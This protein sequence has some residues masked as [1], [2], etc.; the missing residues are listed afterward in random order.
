MKTIFPSKIMIAVLL[1][2]SCGV[3][4]ADTTIVN[5]IDIGSLTTLSSF[6]NTGENYYRFNLPVSTPVSIFLNGLSAGYQIQL[7][8]A[9]G[10]VLKSS[11]NNG[12]TWT[13]ST[14][15]GTTGGAIVAALNGG[16]YYYVRVSPTT[17][18]GNPLYKS[19]D[20]S[21]TVNMIPDNAPNTV[22]VAAANSVPI[23]T[24]TYTATGINDQNIINQAITT[25]GNAGGGTVLL[26][27]GTYV[28]QNNIMINYDN[29]TLTGA[30]WGTVLKLANNTTLF[31]AGLLRSMF[32]STKDR[33]I[34]P[35]FFNQRFMHLS[36]HGNKGGA[37]SS[38]T[39]YGVY[40][41][42]QNSSF[43]DLR[44][45][46][47]PAYGFDTHENPTTLTPT[48]NISIT[49]SLA[50]HNAKNGMTIDANFNSSFTDNVADSNTG[51]GIM[52][53]TDSSHNT[54]ARN[55]ITNNT[56]HGVAI[57]PG[58]TTTRTPIGNIIQN[59]LIKNN[60]AQ[61]V[62][63]SL[64]NYTQILNNTI[65]DN[66]THAIQLRSSSYSTVDGNN[67]NNNARLGSLKT[68]SGVYL[69]DASGVGEIYST[70]NLIQNNMII[71]YTKNAYKYGVGEI[72]SDDDYNQIIGNTISK[73]YIPIQVKGPHSTAAGNIILP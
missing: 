4:L 52:L 7:L 3:S 41:T 62:Y 10:N 35:R 11:S 36:L 32:I 59:N 39:G 45:H 71:G 30:G 63:V 12:T 57:Q 46:D 24:T 17:L 16:V 22:T 9:N 67:L 51:Y 14:N 37:T 25:M 58:S 29:I 56:K 34:K 42:Y 48:D 50:D 64:S 6:K 38:S 1:T 27:P 28:I 69:S 15:P 49:N 26:R 60:L 2:M 47:F 70:H 21:Y 8:D 55:L 66:G 33:V 72:T 53:I 61:G 43:D 65:N 73:A 44:V 18:T 20:G 5:P 31:R 23:G 54:V 13:S 40:G 68:Y 19:L